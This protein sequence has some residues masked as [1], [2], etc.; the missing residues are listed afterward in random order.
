M[1]NRRELKTY[2]K[3]FLSKNY[4]QS[5]L[6]VVVTLFL[7]GGMG[8]VGRTN[9]VQQ[10]RNDFNNISVEE[11]F[12]TENIEASTDVYN[13]VA[14]IV[15][16]PLTILGIG[17]ATVTTIFTALL[18]ISLGFV[19]EV[20]QSRF[21]LD[22]FKG[23]VDIKKLFSGFNSDE[24][25]PIIKAQGL[26]FISIFLWTLLL[27][28]PGIIK[29]YQYRYVPYLLAEDSSLS[30]KAALDKSK[31]LTMGHKMDIFIL[32]LSFFFWNLLGIVTF[33]IAPL[34]VAPYIE[35]TNAR[36]YNVLSN[37]LTFEQY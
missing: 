10:Y 33:G 4:W 2:A 23:D 35:A 29:S 31:S 11:L 30:P 25:L 27:V 9:Y 12:I 6:V 13:S 20:G 8:D 28:V 1:W 19:A 26:A 22:G 16:T 15:L 34:F 3:K 18:L 37:D 7:M 5:F 14:N 36:L 32:D 17:L 21:F 24:Y